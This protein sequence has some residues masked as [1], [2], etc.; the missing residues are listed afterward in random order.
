MELPFI[1]AQF[2][3]IFGEYNRAF[4]PVVVR[5]V[6]VTLAP[7]F[8]F[9]APRQLPMS[10][11]ERVGNA[12]RRNYDLLPDGRRFLGVNPVGN[13]PQGTQIEVVLNWQE[14]LKQRVPSH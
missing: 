6:D 13:G 8:T 14:E 4:W 12:G 9:T 1:A 7:A 2:F 3:A 11:N 5:R 10:L